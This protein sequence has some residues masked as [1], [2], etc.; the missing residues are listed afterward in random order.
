MLGLRA[1]MGRPYIKL[2]ERPGGRSKGVAKLLAKLG[3][4]EYEIMT[5]LGHS[6]PQTTRIYTKEAE[7]E[8]MAISAAQ[9]RMRKT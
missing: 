6:D 7:R 1:Q 5:T 8:R 4:T 2:R 9:K 3:A